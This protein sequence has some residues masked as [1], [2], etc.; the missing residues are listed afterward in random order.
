MPSLLPLGG[1]MS[2]CQRQDRVEYS[3]E[4]VDIKIGKPM[5]ILWEITNDGGIGMTAT[6]ISG[7]ACPQLG[8]ESR[9]EVG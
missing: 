6:K 8:M 9:N 5:Q 1:P 7:T 4:A 2:V 3:T